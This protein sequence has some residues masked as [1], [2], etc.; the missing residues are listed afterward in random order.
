[1]T[2][3]RDLSLN[4]NFITWLKSITNLPIIIKGILA[5][6]DAILGC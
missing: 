3:Q 6:D 2:Q 4:W 5:V 1:M